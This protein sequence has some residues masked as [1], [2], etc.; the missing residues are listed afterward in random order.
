MN[1]ILWWEKSCAIAPISDVSSNKAHAAN[2]SVWIHNFSWMGFWNHRCSQVEQGLNSSYQK[3]INPQNFCHF[4]AFLA[5][6]NDN[7]IILNVVLGIWEYGNMLQYDIEVGYFRGVK[8]F[9]KAHK[10]SEN[11]K[12]SVTSATRFRSQFWLSVST[13]SVFDVFSRQL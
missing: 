11:R 12:R 1:M 3:Q 6:Y 2:V 4:Y 13:C 8:Y 9:C 7:K 5:F 10:S